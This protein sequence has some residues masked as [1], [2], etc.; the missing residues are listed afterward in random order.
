[1]RDKVTRA[2]MASV[3]KRPFSFSRKSL[4]DSM[5]VLLLLLIT[6]QHELQEK[7]DS[8]ELSISCFSLVIF[9]NAKTAELWK[10]LFYRK[11]VFYFAPI[12][13]LHRRV[14]NRKLKYKLVKWFLKRLECSAELKIC[15]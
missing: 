3:A 5:Y 11:I 2:Q 14:S 4:R 6:R 1:M 10:A 15:V 12:G 9:G 13:Y 8:R 7:R